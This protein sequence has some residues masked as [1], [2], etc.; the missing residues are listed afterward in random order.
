MDNNNNSEVFGCEFWTDWAD[1]NIE[2]HHIK[3]NVGCRSDRDGVPGANNQ[4]AH[5]T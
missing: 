2:L 3:L 1:D 4:N 5:T